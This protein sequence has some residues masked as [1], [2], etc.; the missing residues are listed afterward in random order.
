MHF[1]RRLVLALMTLLFAVLVLVLWPRIKPGIGEDEK[2]PHVAVPKA[3]AQATIA[4]SNAAPGTLARSL[5]AATVLPETAQMRNA[6]IVG[7]GVPEAIK[8]GTVVERVDFAPDAR[9]EFRRA[10]VYRT[11]FK[12]PLVRVDQRLQRTSRG[13]EKL[14][15]QIVMVADHLMVKVQP[16]TDETM[17]RQHLA[18]L[19]ATVRKHI[20]GSS[21]YLVAVRSARIAD[22][23]A[24]LS[25]LENTTSSVAF[26]E[27]DFIVHAT[28][29]PNDPSFGLQWNMHNTG[30]TGGTADADI[31]AP[32]AWDITTGSTSV[33][34]GVIDTGMDLTHPDLAAN[35]W[36]NASEIPGNG[37]D[38]DN[39]GYID[40]VHGWNFVS[41][42]NSPNDDH[43]HGSHTAGTVG[44]AGGNG[45]GVTGVCQ[46]VR[47]MPLKFLDATGNGTDS[48]AL[49]A[50]LYATAKGVLLT[51]NSWGGGSFDPLLLQA[52]QDAGT[53]GVGFVAAAGNSGINADLYPEYPAAYNSAN[54]ISV[55]ATDSTD[56]LAWF[57]NYGAQAV[58]IGAPGVAT[59][60]TTRNAGYATMSGT[61][62]ATPHVAGAAALLKA[63][64]P[65]LT[66]AQ[67]KGMLLSQGDT[68]SSLNGKT[69][70]GRRLNVANALVPATGP[71][72]AKASVT[73][74]DSAGGDGNGIASPGETVNV[75]IAATNLGA[76]PANDV[77][78]TLA[79]S[80]APLD[81][82]LTSS[83][84]SYGTIN[85]AA[86]V[87][88]TATP[89]VI[90]IGSSVTPADVTMTLTLTDSA[91]HSWTLTYTLQIRNVTT[92]AGTVTKI[93]GGDPFAGATVSI[94]GAETHALTT[95]PNGHYSI[96]L[97]NGTY[98]VQAS[99]PGY[100]PS[101]AHTLTVP[102]SQTSLNFALGY[103]Q[104]VV[105]PLS[106]T[107][108]QLEGET[109]TQTF[110]IQNNGDLPLTFTI[111][112][113]PPSDNTSSSLVLSAPPVKTDTKAFETMTG[114]NALHSRLN[115]Q[116]KDKGVSLPQ[117]D[118]AGQ[119]W[120]DYVG[121][122]PVR[123]R[124]RDASDRWACLLPFEDNFE[125][126]MWGRWWNTGGDGIREVV[127][128]TAGQGSHSFHFHFNGPDDHFTGV[129]QI[130]DWQNPGHISF[131]I[132]PGAEDLATAYMVLLDDYYVFDAFGFH[133]QI[134][135]FIWFF[136]NANGRFYLNDDAGGNQ[137]VVYTEG[138]WYHIEFRNI[139]WTTHS[140]DY[141]V[142]GTLVQAGVPFRNPN[143][144]YE[145]VF[146]VTY[147]YS[148]D[149][150][151]GLDDAKFYA[152]ALPWLSLSST[153]GTVAPGSST[154]ITA[155][156][157]AT[158]QL[159]GH[160]TG[161]LQV[162]TNDPMTPNASV[163]VD[164]TVTA[165]P[166]A[167]PVALSQSLTLGLNATQTIVLAGSDADNDPLSC[168][169]V[170]LPAHGKLY[171]TSDGVTS[172]LQITNTPTVVT[173]PQWKV[174]YK[175]DTGI[176][177]AHS[178]DFAFITHDP[179]VPSNV[180]I[181]GIDVTSWPLFTVTP[182]SGTLN[183]P[184][185]AVFKTSDSNAVVRLSP[186]GSTS[187]ITIANGGTFLV[188]H[189]MT[190]SGVAALGSNVGPPQPVSFTFDDNN[191][192]GVPDW[193]QS[194][195][196]TIASVSDDSDGDGLTNAQEFVAGTNPNSPDRFVGNAQSSSGTHTLT[197]Q[198]VLGRV[199]VVESSNDMQSWQQASQ[200]QFGTGSV[201]TW[202]DA[203]PTPAEFYRVKVSLQ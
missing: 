51:S 14:G 90:E 79:L 117:L 190:F 193:W 23:D 15:G 37:I 110:T 4:A 74:D 203:S 27:P 58:H 55:A 35:L 112:D 139:S 98:T 141:W 6:G 163:S 81:V 53:A 54:I 33:V 25:A 179:K 160:Y 169:I 76:L 121:A 187:S 175:T 88:N 145:M 104:G 202:Q 123:S 42:N 64:N 29:L 41:N 85:A 62:M 95:D 116:L 137:A 188:D 180:A 189:T 173:H 63:A 21:I 56:T 138:E 170:G 40:D 7:A 20:P 45:I 128:N 200:P 166:N 16:G 43:G 82:S 125:D 132:R 80:G 26:A 111:L 46:T 17:L 59:Y 103:S 9:G 151:M 77:Q 131:W 146:A 186:T 185:N 197:W 22:F 152:D 10:T 153:Q 130:F 69:S 161:S 19:G 147:N 118:R 158:T 34:V 66:F 192:D 11:N 172:G 38:D 30:Q 5:A 52:I 96:N 67:I 60:S 84:A 12:Y 31:D 68:K 105:S 92:I 157:D 174:I 50:V 114:N 115:R 49:E 72:L 198:S 201:M 8:Q 126:G 1:S 191:G 71:L 99:A 156:F 102:P 44:A 182:S 3:V 184:T 149:T 48:D 106:L 120:P 61:S 154:T 73:V 195:H 143:A 140:F 162:R 127:A 97:P 65:A 150:D 171:Q 89:F 168:R 75:V 155:T 87:S 108:T 135:D 18:A 165:T 2:S 178:G 144:T 24:A 194:Q 183:A 124:T 39:N 159:S 148:G 70:T 107:S 100:I 113:V 36:T 32:E 164:M 28:S 119:T 177:G 109:K 101:A 57:S 122:P 133:E 129:H 142:D 78:G 94:S 136:A 196:P 199:Y 47:L 13:D 91:S 167:V 83:T 134:T 176:S 93:T 181:V 86:T